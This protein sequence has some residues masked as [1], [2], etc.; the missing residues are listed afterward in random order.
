M[1]KVIAFL[2]AVI[3]FVFTTFAFWQVNVEGS[4]F[5]H[6]AK[7]LHGTAVAVAGLDE[8]KETSNDVLAKK[9]SNKAPN[10]TTV[11]GKR[12]LPRA[13]SVILTFKNFLAFSATT[14]NT[15]GIAGTATPLYCRGSIYLNN[16]VL[17][18]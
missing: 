8:P 5:V 6:T 9:S 3:Y 13:S 12:N 2:F 18:I 15:P 11:T 1:K 14:S 16:G 10:H 7:S 17:R 4:Y